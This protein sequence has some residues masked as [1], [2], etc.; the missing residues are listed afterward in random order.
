MIRPTKKAAFL[1]ALSI[2][3]ALLVV[4]INRGI[5]YFSL[6]LP[7]FLLAFI[8]WD[9][10]TALPIQRLTVT[11]DAP[12]QIFLGNTAVL[13]V[14]L[15]APQFKPQFSLQCRLEQ[16]GDLEDSL[17]VDGVMLSETL[18][19][20]LPLIPL[21]RGKIHLKALWLRWNGPFGLTERI[22]RHPISM[23][24]NI[25]PDTSAIY[26]TALSFLT[27]DNIYGEKIQRNKGGGTEF[28]DLR[29]YSA[30]MDVRMI[31]WKRSAR[32]RKLLSK[33]F[34]EERNHHI[35]FGFDTGHLMI[36][37]INGIPKLD[38]AIKSALLLSWVSL[39]NGDFV[40]G[41]A[42]DVRFRGY[43]RPG[44]GLRYFSQIQHF[45]TELNYH[46]EET[47]FTLGLAELNSRL[48]RRA[49]VV[50]FTEFID[51]ISAD[52]LIESLRLMTRKHLVIFLTLK[53][54]L[55]VNLRE[56]VPDNFSSIAQAVIADNFLRERTAVLQ[57][58]SRLGVH[59]LDVPHHS[60]SAA[61]LNRYLMIKGR[62]LL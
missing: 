44:R 56:A 5:W 54:P 13:E 24:V 59:C 60:L 14:K 57:R 1:F 51:Q 53:D 30:G 28:E 4:S 46:S 8:T 16:E 39:R 22:Y 20:D 29:E 12:K 15:S 62:G 2:P 23:V 11:L 40:G 49:L 35:I 41:A 61:L 6:Y 45:S 47:N 34:R 37:P 25:V 50:L 18:K 55:L 27:H 42:F 38:H 33:E 3:I 7:L 17:L 19:L 36:E 48:K 32:H 43:L 10:I 26:D 31:D 58:I 21:R 52:L 9:A